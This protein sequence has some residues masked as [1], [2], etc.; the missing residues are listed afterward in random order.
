[1]NKYSASDFKRMAVELIDEIQ[2]TGELIYVQR[3]GKDAAVL[4]S[5]EEFKK[6]TN[7]N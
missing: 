4:I 1:M 5:F 7:S 3:K 2:A 6:L